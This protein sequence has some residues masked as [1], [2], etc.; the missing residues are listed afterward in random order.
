MAGPDGQLVHPVA[1]IKRS[2]DMMVRLIADLRD[3]G[4][5][6]AGHLS[7]QTRPEASAGLVRD[8]I[9]G[10]KDA[11]A[12]KSLRLAVKMPARMPTKI[13]ATSSRPGSAATSRTST[14]RIPGNPSAA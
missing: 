5:I 1:I 13:S 6:E 7:I 2:V 11:A 10:I 14:A 12:Q 8:A 9:E 3:V 4:S